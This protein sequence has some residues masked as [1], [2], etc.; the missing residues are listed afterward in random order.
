MNPGMEWL[1]SAWGIVTGILILLLYY[2]SMLRRQE[3]GQLFIEE[4]AIKVNGTATTD[5]QREQDKSSGETGRRNFGPDDLGNRGL[6][7]LHWIELS[8]AIGTNAPEVCAPSDELA[9]RS[10]C[11]FQGWIASCVQTKVGRPRSAEDST[12]SRPPPPN[13]LELSNSPTFQSPLFS[14]RQG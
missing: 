8:I 4:S 7:C 6:G 5:C 2:R 14:K 1:L 3:D 13:A 12:Q 11:L 10:A 9:S